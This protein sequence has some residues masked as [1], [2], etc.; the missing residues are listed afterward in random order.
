MGKKKGSSMFGD[1]AS[2]PSEAERALAA[3]LAP[4]VRGLYR[5]SVEQGIDAIGQ[6]LFKELYGG[7]RERYVGT[8]A[9]HPSLRILL[10]WCTSVRLPPRRTFLSNALRLAA[11][12][13]LFEPEAAFHMLPPSHR[14]ELLRLRD[15]KKIEPLAEIVL[16][17][18]HTIKDL[19]HAIDE[20]LGLL[21]RKKA[22]RVFRL[23]G[24]MIHSLTN[25]A[26]G[27][28]VITHKDVEDYTP[29][30]WA[31][32]KATTRAAMARM[33]ALDEVLGD[34]PPAPKPPKEK[35]AESKVV[36]EKK[37]AEGSEVV[38]TQAAEVAEVPEVE[39]SSPRIEVSQVGDFDDEDEDEDEEI[40]LVDV[41]AWTVTRVPAKS[42]SKPKSSRRRDGGEGVAKVVNKAGTV[43]D[44]TVGGV[45]L[46]AASPEDATDTGKPLG[47]GG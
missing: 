5:G 47:G 11:H 18:G 29:K 2:Q 43:P 30:A 39:S 1:A 21:Q 41:R 45:N 12:G 25:Q 10:S 31:S 40:E 37:P 27:E 9:S 44:A 20:A 4:K 19:R 35:P 46:G 3:A 15:P 24:A 28:L 16:E 13:T 22:P 38:V 17:E 36:E 6:L 32:A 14:I 42:G 26:T 7:E 8:G 33:K 23:V 34:E